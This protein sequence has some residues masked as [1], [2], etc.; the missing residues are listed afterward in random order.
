MVL[1][2]TTLLGRDINE[3]RAGEEHT[4]GYT[5]YDLTVNYDTRTLRCV[6]AR[7][8]EPAR[9]S[10]TSCRSRRSTSS[11]TIFAGRGRTVSLTYRIDF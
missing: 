8:R 3:G 6:L 10:S 2:A 5:L 11:A 1:G 9:T 7:R 4:H